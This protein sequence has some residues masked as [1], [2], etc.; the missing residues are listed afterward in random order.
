MASLIMN[1]E[2]HLDQVMGCTPSC[3]RDLD[4]V[5]FFLK[6]RVCACVGMVDTDS[7]FRFCFHQDELKQVDHYF[8]SPSASNK[9][10]TSFEQSVAQ[11]NQIASSASYSSKGKRA[12]VVSDAPWT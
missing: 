11:L 2:T 1:W 4:N 7:V 9:S 10:D 8:S 12:S 3:G 6:N 5:S